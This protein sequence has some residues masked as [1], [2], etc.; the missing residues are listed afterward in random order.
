VK[1]W[2]HERVDPTPSKRVDHTLHRLGFLAKEL[3]L[4]VA[5]LPELGIEV[6]GH[7]PIPGH[8]EEPQPRRVDTVQERR[9]LPCGL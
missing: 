1:S 5:V 6:A 8:E 4:K 3:Q 7:V 2:V 9:F